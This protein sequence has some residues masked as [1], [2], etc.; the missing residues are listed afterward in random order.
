MKLKIQPY[1]LCL[2]VGFANTGVA[3]WDRRSEKFAHLELVKTVKTD[4]HYVSDDSISR[5]QFIA[6]TLA[7]IMD[8][9]TPAVVI[10]EMPH[11]GS[12]NSSALRCM[13]LA[14]ATVA[15]ICELR[16]A[17]LHVVR[18]QEI[19]DLVVPSGGKVGKKMVQAFVSARYGQAILKGFPAALREH[20]ADAIMCLDVYL[21]AKNGK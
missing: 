3:V 6:S 1:Y 8:R 15:T 17:K 10:A 19:K 9:Y 13:M 5:C 21:Q 16:G 7:T 2:D 12:R 4:A 14:L 20:V 18:P 11:G